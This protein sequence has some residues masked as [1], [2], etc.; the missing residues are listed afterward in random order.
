[1]LGHRIEDDGPGRFR[2]VFMIEEY[3]FNL[4]GVSRVQAEVRTAIAEC[5]T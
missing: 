1:M 5:R 2:I 3:E 4:L